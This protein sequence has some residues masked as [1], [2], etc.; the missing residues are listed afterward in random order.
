MPSESYLPDIQSV[1]DVGQGTNI[2]MELQGMDSANE[3]DEAQK[4]IHTDDTSLD[5]KANA[6]LVTTDIKVKPMK[7]VEVKPKHKL[8]PVNLDE[9][10]TKG[11][12]N[13]INSE[14]G[15]EVV[16]R[17]NCTE[18]VSINIQLPLTPKQQR[19]VRV[20]HAEYQDARIRLTKDQVKFLKS[21]G[22][23]G[24]SD[25]VM[26]LLTVPSHTPG[27]RVKPNYKL[28]PVNLD[29]TCTKGLIKAINN[30]KGV[31]LVARYEHTKE[32]VSNNIRMPL[33]P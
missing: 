1:A 33:T 12:I 27:E 2:D 11:L 28:Y 25:C 16:A 10:C 32:V 30:E 20:K 13:A 19:N 21:S 18:S 8:Y 4:T 31:V 23:S 3:W 6:I 22:W 15:V 29:E 14:K 24:L 26:S 9:T 5:E 7:G 17:Y